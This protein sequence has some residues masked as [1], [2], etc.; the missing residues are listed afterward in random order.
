LSAGLMC[1]YLG[2]DRRPFNPLLAS[3]PRVMHM[4]G[5]ADAWVRGLTR[6]VAEERRLSRPGSESVITRL[7]E[8][9]FVEVLRRY[10]EELP[11]GQTGWLAGLRDEVVGRVLS[12]I[13]A[14]PGHPWTLE[15]LAREANS[16]RTS[17]AKR[18]AELVG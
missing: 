4:R 7:A 17:V 16:S 8:L 2:C 18:F 6:Q 11:P 5:M 12:L 9:M 13:H 10:L 14:R 15:E 3:L 1:G